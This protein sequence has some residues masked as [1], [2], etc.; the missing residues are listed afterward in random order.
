MRPLNRRPRRSARS[1]TP[2]RRR[3]GRT[4][5]ASATAGTS[6]SSCCRDA[7]ATKPRAKLLELQ[8]AI[9]AIVFEVTGR[10][11]VQLAVSGGAAVF[12]QD[13]NPTRRCWPW[14]TAG[15]TRTRPRARTAADDRSRLPVRR[16]V[17]R[18]SRS[19]RAGSALAGLGGSATRSRP[20]L[21]CH[22]SCRASA[23]TGDASTRRGAAVP[24]LRPARPHG[25]DWPPQHVRQRRIRSPGLPADAATSANV[26]RTARRSR[27]QTTA[28]ASLDPLEPGSVIAAPWSVRPLPA[29]VADPDRRRCLFVGRAERES[30][31]CARR[32]GRAR[33]GPAV[34]LDVV[35]SARTPARP[36]VR[37]GVRRLREPDRI[38]YW[39]TV[40]RRARYPRGAGAGRSSGRCWT[41]ARSGRQPVCLVCGSANRH[42][43]YDGADAPGVASPHGDGRSCG[44]EGNHRGRRRVDAQRASATGQAL[45]RP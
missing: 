19:G 3:S 26:P 8:Q 14:P 20:R 37:R 39:P 23:S 15:C 40:P 6:S 42:G 28:G 41:N 45:D 34:P 18:R 13:G 17:E 10:Q 35:Y 38:R 33:G 24:V 16:A 36:G 29:S 9:D 30:P 2:W 22:P 25:M 7:A 1:P 43:R 44:E 11:R 5:C 4:T 27:H 21:E 32:C 31:H 12:P